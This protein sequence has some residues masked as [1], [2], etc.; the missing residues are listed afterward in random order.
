[1]TLETP[2]VTSDD[3]WQWRFCSGQSCE[4]AENMKYEGAWWPQWRI[5]RL[6]LVLLSA[7]RVI[8]DWDIM[9][10]PEKSY[11]WTPSFGFVHFFFEQWQW[12]A[13]AVNIENCNELFFWMFHLSAR[14]PVWQV[15][16]GPKSTNNQRNLLTRFAN[17][18]TIN[19]IYYLLLSRFDC[20][21]SEGNIV[22]ADQFFLS[23]VDCDNR[24]QTYCQALLKFV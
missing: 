1:M 3:I 5:L 15:R 10:I 2:G 14:S 11:K 12:H 20:I 24:V 18:P 22:A 16:A 9:K 8:S 7:L 6:L 21:K 4:V 17:I 23:H 19:F 13:W